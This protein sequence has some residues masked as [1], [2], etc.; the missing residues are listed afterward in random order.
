MNIKN[1]I[2]CLLFILPLGMF[3]KHIERYKWDENP[4]LHKLSADYDKESAVIIDN[5][6]REEYYYNANN[7]ID[8]YRTVHMVV[9]LNDDKAIERYNKVYVSMHNV[10]LVVEIKARSIAKDGTVK[11]VEKS[12]MK[13]LDQNDN[14]GSYKIFAIDGLEKGSEIEYYYILKKYPMYFDREYMQHENPVMHARIEIISPEK[15]FFKSKSYNKFPSL[16][17][18]V[19]GE[20]N[21]L[22]A[23]A[24]NIPELKKEEY[25][26]YSANLMRVE[27]KINKTTDKEDKDLLTWQDAA[28]T[29]YERTYLGEQNSNYRTKVGKILKEIFTKDMD[30]TAKVCAI[31]NYIKTNFALKSVNGDDI[32]NFNNMLK[33]KYT[34]ETG[35]V[36][37]FAGFLTEAKI[38]HELVLT[39]DRKEI[40]FD[41]DFESWNFLENYAIYFPN[42]EKYLAPTEM[43]YRFPLIPA[44]W[45]ENDA[46]FIKTVTLGGKQIGYGEV[47]RIP[48][49]ETE[50]S[51]DNID[52]SVNFNSDLSD[53]TSHVK[54]SFSGY[55]AMPIQPFVRLLTAEK[56]K[57]ALELLLKDL[58][59]E[60]KVSNI[61]VENDD[62][63]VSPFYKP[64]IVE[65]DL[66]GTG[67]L[68]QAGHDYLFKVGTL[69][70]AQS[71][72]YADK[73][74]DNPVENDFK[75]RYDRNITFN[76]P[77]G[78][79]IKNLG[80]LKM[81]A[82]HLH[83]GQPDFG[84]NSTYKVEGDK[85][86][87]RV[88]EFYKN[89]TAPIS[90][91]EAFRKVINASADFNKVTLVME[92]E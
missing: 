56:R 60:S 84:F 49:T 88:E 59:K 6:V 87:I 73:K 44:L 63:N 74:R 47:K 43:S 51:Y 82:S 18:T 9:K 2:F 78:Y 10:D 19:I 89:L 58:E 22:V 24:N 29:V 8:M 1:K 67:F 50:I 7:N 61:K 20:K 79:K 35:M 31:E 16:R 80:D 91:F 57:E 66:Q 38:K 11:E 28:K 65:G 17:D 23:E 69:I 46:L 33:N 48:T 4:V 36:K 86:I 77:K 81:D 45:T 37:L 30:E 27:V 72:L 42:L 92:K 15:I 71:Q 34:G 14:N 68:E 53:A 54:R 32:T 76:I 12:A 13:M 39:T 52:V 62:Y 3:A 25:S 85:V 75:H 5:L 90:E 83:N 64:M 55:N 70:G 21:Y 40:R 26:S 41:G